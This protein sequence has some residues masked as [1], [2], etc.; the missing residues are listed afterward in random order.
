MN[1][2]VSAIVIE[3]DLGLVEEL[4][5]REEAAL[6]ESTRVASAT[7]RKRRPTCPAV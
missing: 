7:A 4:T 2:S 3:I 1:G 6:D 5:K